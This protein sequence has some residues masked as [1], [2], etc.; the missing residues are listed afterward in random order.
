MLTFAR[1]PVR[2]GVQQLRGGDKRGF[3]N[4]FLGN[5]LKHRSSDLDRSTLRVAAH[6]AAAAA[7]DSRAK[8]FLH[9]SAR[10]PN[11]V[12]LRGIGLKCLFG[13][14]SRFEN[15]L[16]AKGTERLLECT[17][18]PLYRL[19]RVIAA[20]ARLPVRAHEPLPNNRERYHHGDPL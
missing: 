14:R 12:G 16:N 6:G 18:G 9:G 13:D 19:I 1:W 2:Y 3:E 7:A 4:E 17:D 11:A 8:P 15:R 10:D 20:I 5:C